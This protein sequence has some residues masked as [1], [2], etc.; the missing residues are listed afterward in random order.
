MDYKSTFLQTLNED[1]VNMTPPDDQVFSANNPGFTDDIEGIESAGADADAAGPG[2]DISRYHQTT[3]EYVQ[4]IN[5]VGEALEKRV[6]SALD[7]LETADEHDNKIYNAV[8]KNFRGMN[9]RLAQLK[10]SL[11][12][13]DTDIKHKKIETFRRNK[14]RLSKLNKS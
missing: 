1:A 5:K 9:T 8:I 14:E 7:K 2:K 11:V 3:E 4:F 6:K 12:D 13:I 10:D